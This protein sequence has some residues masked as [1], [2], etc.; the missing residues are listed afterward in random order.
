MTQSQDL[1]QSHKIYIIGRV[2]GGGDPID[3]V[4]HGDPSTQHTAVLDV[5]Y[6]VGNMQLVV[7]LVLRM[8]QSIRIYAH[9]TI[10]DFTQRSQ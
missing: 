9:R 5:V 6:S 10:N 7:F 2:D 3:A 1:L 8:T 4:S